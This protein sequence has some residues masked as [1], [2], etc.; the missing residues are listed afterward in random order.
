MFNQPN[1]NRNAPRPS[2]RD[3][4]KQDVPDMDHPPRAGRHDQPG[5]DQANR[6]ADNEARSGEP[7]HRPNAPDATK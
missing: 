3:D 7:T 4:L 5:F 6:A 2:P 1:T